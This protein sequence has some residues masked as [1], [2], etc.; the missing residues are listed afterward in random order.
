MVEGEGFEPSKPKAGDL[1]SDGFDRSPTPPTRD[2]Q[3]YLEFAGQWQLHFHFLDGAGTKNRTRDLLI[4][5]QLLYQLSYTGFHEKRG[6]LYVFT[7]ADN[8]LL[9]NF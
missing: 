5:S 2:F 7:A 8:A 1:Q 3:L 4:T 9:P 6:A